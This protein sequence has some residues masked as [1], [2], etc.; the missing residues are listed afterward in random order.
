MTT[1]T[2]DKKRV[3]VADGVT[4]LQ[5]ARANGI[6][7]PTLCSHEAL[8]P[9]GSCRLCVVEV[10]ENGRNRVVTSCNYEARGG[11]TVR[12]RSAAVLNIRKLVAELLLARSPNVKIVRKLACEIGVEEPRFSLENEACIRC[13]LC[14]RVCQEIVGASA[15]TFVKRGS[16]VQPAPPFGRPAEDCI[17]CGAC[18]Y[19]CPAKCITMKDVE[20]AVS[21]GPEGKE[22][23]P[24]ARVVEN[25][26]ARLT[27]TTCSGCGNPC[28]PRAGP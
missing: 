20:E 4:L 28:A 11:L 3:K 27:L 1:L 16:E 21:I 13:G 18:V 5:A 26:R 24:F 8:S 9:S 17:G 25:W 19:V 23:L 6:H 12:T 14:V 10:S 2:I 22:T 7:I 15:I